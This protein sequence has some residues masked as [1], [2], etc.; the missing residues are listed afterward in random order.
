MRYWEKGKKS[1]L[2]DAEQH[3]Q[4]NDDDDVNEAV[5]EAEKAHHGHSQLEELPQRQG[6]A[7]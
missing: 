5:E 6:T 1:I 3:K 7:L 4:Q 2:L